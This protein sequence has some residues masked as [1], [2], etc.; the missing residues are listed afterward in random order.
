MRLLAAG[1]QSLTKLAPERFAPVE[2]EVARSRGQAEEL[3]WPGT[4]QPLK[5]DG[6]LCLG[7]KPRRI[8]L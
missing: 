4:A 5:I 2:A 6:E 7:L 8:G 3:L 1:G